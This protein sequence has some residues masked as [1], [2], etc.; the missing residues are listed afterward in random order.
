MT[1]TAMQPGPLQADPAYLVAAP[2][3]GFLGNE[4]V[5]S[6]MDGFRD[7]YPRAALWIVTHEDAGTH[8]R[9]SM[10]ELRDG[11]GLPDEVVVLPLFLTRH[12]AL[13][14]RARAVIRDLGAETTVRWAEPLGESYL[15]EEILF[16]RV[17]SLSEEPDRERLVLVGTGAATAEAAEG[18][19]RDLL[20]LARRATGKYGL[21]D[22]A[23][24]E[25][26][27]DGSAPDSLREGMLERVGARVDSLASDGARP[28]VVPFGFARRYS[29]MMSDWNWLGHQ[30]A[31]GG[32][33]YR[34]ETVLPHRNVEYWLRRAATRHRELAPEEVG[35]VFVPHG[36]DYDWNQTM[37][38][39]LAPLRDDFVTAE[40]FSM[41]DPTVLERA[42]RR[43]ED[44]GMK[45]AVVVRIFSLESSF[46]EKAEYV[47]GLRR[48]HDRYPHRIRTPLELHTLGG[49]ERTPYL[50][51]A[52]ADRV[53]EISEAPSRETVILLG[54]GTGDDETNERWMENLEHLAGEMEARLDGGFRAFLYHNWREDW[55]EQRKEA[56]ATIREMVREASEDGGTA[57]VVPVRTAAQGPAREYLQGMEYRYA[58]GFAPHPAFA[59]WV[60]SEIERGLAALRPPAT[61]TRMAGTGDGDREER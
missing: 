31:G 21:S 12:H 49:M 30:L 52:L 19:R 2:D 45:A 13:Y 51:E 28:L 47:L 55:P 60:R 20:P 23:T 33:G 46:R 54:H 8:L 53:R 37:R 50:A 40:A 41:V 39:G 58:T 15:A 4:Q 3:R 6:A 18:I 5:R 24:V 56:V 59:E 26:L 57:L 16:D 29:S 61:E 44:R 9:A 48:D 38:E 14:D 10:Q 22:S 34:E 17:E 42:I 43:L 25:V 32:V 11:S 1:L 35:V 36:A 27:F 7:A